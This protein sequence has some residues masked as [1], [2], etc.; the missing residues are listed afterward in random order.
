MGDIGLT[1]RSRRRPPRMGCCDPLAGE[2]LLGLVAPML[3][4]ER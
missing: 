4:A 1:L 2:A 3:G